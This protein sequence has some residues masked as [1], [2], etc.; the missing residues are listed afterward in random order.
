LVGAGMGLAA[1]TPSCDRIKQVDENLMEAGEGV[2]DE[3]RGAIRGA[4]LVAVRIGVRSL[5]L[6]DPAMR[7]V[8][9][10]L[11]LGG[12]L[13]VRYVKLESGESAEE[14]FELE[15]GEAE[16]LERQRRIVVVREDGGEEEVLIG[17]VKMAEY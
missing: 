3:Y 15:E 16:E 11:I 2:P 14:K 8:G 9:V 5:Q 13:L 1:G 10:T 7:V 4:A 6:G 12:L 17:E